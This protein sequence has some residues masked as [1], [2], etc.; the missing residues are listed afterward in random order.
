MRS[1]PLVRLRP[2][3]RSSS[4]E[5]GLLQVGSDPR[6]RVLLPDTSSVRQLVHMLPRG[7]RVDE[8]GD[9][10]RVGHTLLAAGLL[11]DEDE[12]TLLADAR[13][14][15]LVEVIAPAA[16]LPRTVTL[17]HDAGLGV[18]EAE[19][20]PDEVAAGGASTD[21]A[22]AP[23]D[24]TLF[25]HDGELDRE[26]VDHLV[27]D[28]TPLL[29]VGVV[30]ARVRV[31]PFVVPGSSACL[32][33]LDAHAAERDPW[34]RTRSQ[35]LPVTE[36]SA[37]VAPL[38]L[39][40]ALVTAVADLCAWAEGRQPITWCA[41]RSYDETLAMEQTPTP[42]HPHCGCTWADGLVTA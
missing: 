35:T 32:R 13:A 38:V 30:D 31:G 33:C 40:Q 25:V 11:V 8:L 1:N 17:V 3:V 21:S 9:L 28:E 22:A 39:T 4:R 24:L 34:F 10:V 23:P 15:T 18:H 29:P 14:S 20:C 7:L 6:R 37:V 41:T 5:D 36:S 42:R 12:R 19:T 27:R 26:L 16:W 2:G